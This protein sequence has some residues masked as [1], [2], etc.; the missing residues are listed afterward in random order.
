M[1]SVDNT[2]NI[3]ATQT[4]NEFYNNNQNSNYQTLTTINDAFAN[5]DYQTA[6]TINSSLTAN[7]L[8]EEYQ[9]RVNEL[10]IKYINYQSQPV[11]SNATPFT[12]KTPVF[13]GIELAELSTIANS[14]F[15]KYGSVITQARVLMNNVS[16][17]LIEFEENCKPEF[18]QRK[19]QISNSV[20]SNVNVKLYPNPNKGLMQLDY[21]LGNSQH[22]TIKLYDINGKLI[23][24]Y[25]LDSN[26]GIL[27]MNEQNLNNGI[28]FYHILVGEKTIKT[29]KV[30][31]I[32]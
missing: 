8:I 28:Y 14:C 12:Y 4:L 22:A 30:V 31:I 18:N 16:N 26:K 7:N 15:D 25:K 17:T 5:A 10:L 3:D 24:S 32:K 6:Q 19:K 20:A 1:G 21:D 9:K 23:S 27:Q 13:D 11:D 2:K 29:D